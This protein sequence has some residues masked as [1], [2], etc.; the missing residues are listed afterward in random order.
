[1]NLAML[2]IFGSRERRV[3]EF[4]TLAAAHRLILDQVTD[5]SDQR[6]LLEFRLTDH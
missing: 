1:M 2:T 3:D 6:C 4:R 5:L